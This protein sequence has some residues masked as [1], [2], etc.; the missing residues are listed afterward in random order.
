MPYCASWAHKAYVVAAV[1]GDTS[2]PGFKD[3]S[4]CRGLDSTPCQLMGHQE[5]RLRTCGQPKMRA[6]CSKVLRLQDVWSR[7]GTSWSLGQE[8][9]EHI[10]VPCSEDSIGRGSGAC[11]ESTARSVMQDCPRAAVSHMLT[12]KALGQG[13]G[14]CCIHFKMSRCLHMPCGELTA[15]ASWKAAH[16][17]QA[18]N[19]C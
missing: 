10:Q 12:S 18:I 11:F 8:P 3:P 5:Y 7:P 14:C 1:P 2:S 13:A 19:M 4:F 15:T 6:L 17:Q 16:G 9:E